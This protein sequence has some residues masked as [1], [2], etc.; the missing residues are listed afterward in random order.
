MAPWGPADRPG[1]GKWMSRAEWSGL[2]HCAAAAVASRR[3]RRA[4]RPGT[5]RH[6]SRL[7]AAS[8]VLDFCV[9]YMMLI[10]ER[11]GRRK[12]KGF[13]W[14]GLDFWMLSFLC[15]GLRG[16]EDELDNQWW[17]R[18]MFILPQSFIFTFCDMEET[19]WF[20]VLCTRR[21]GGT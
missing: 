1:P 12:K 8:L 18:Q 13:F 9:G 17:W 10:E 11:E 15:C 14:C 16:L 7:F 4:P 21:R 19:S 20:V 3:W 6:L 2:L 5:G